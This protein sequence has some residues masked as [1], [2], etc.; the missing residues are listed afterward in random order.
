MKFLNIREENPVDSLV[1]LLKQGDYKKASITLG[2][3]RGNPDEFLKLFKYVTRNTRLEQTVLDINPVK[4][5]VDCPQCGWR[6]DPDIKPNGV[7][8]PKCRGPVRIL[9]GHEFR[10][11]V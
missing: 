5:K 4:A 9:K 2:Q 7:S 1:E 3:L 8:C 11:H 6:G 10:V